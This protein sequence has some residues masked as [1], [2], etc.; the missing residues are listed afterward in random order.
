MFLP[1]ALPSVI[2]TTSA[3]T[4]PISFNPVEFDSK[5]TFETITSNS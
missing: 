2:F 5:I 3:M 4:L 1:S